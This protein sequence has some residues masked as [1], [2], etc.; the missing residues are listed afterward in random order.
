VA[1][2]GGVKSKSKYFYNGGIKAIRK[3]TTRCGYQLGGTLNHRIRVLSPDDSIQWRYLTEIQPGDVA[4]LHRGTDLW[5]SEET[6]IP[7]TNVIRSMKNVPQDIL[8]SSRLTVC[9]FIRACFGGR[10]FETKHQRMAQ[11]IQ[12]L[13]L[14]LGIISKTYLYSGKWTVEIIGRKSG[15]RFA[16]LIDPDFKAPISW[17]NDGPDP[18]YFCDDI[19]RIEDSEAPVYDLNVPE[20][21]SFVASGFVNHNTFLAAA[22]A[23]YE[24]YK[25]ILKGC[26]QDYYGL[27]PTNTIQIISVAT[28]KDQAGLLYQEV[29]GHYKSCGFFLPYTANN[30]QSF[31][32]FQTP[33]DI[34]KFGRYVDD[35]GGAKATL[36]VTFRSCIAKG[37]RGAGNIVVILDE[38]A[39]FTDNGQS[40]A[41]EVYKAVTPS[42]STF[43]AKDPITKMPLPGPNGE[44][45]V[46]ESRVISISSPL[47]KSGQF[48]KLFQLAMK[49]GK[50]A[51]NMLA[52]QAPTWEVNP[53]IPISELESEYYKDSASFLVEF[54]GQFSSRTRG[55][56]EREVDLQACVEPGLR[57]VLS[58]PARRPH[59][60]GIDVGLV[61]DWTAIA[62]GHHDVRDGERVVLLDYI[63]RIHAGEGRYRDK[64]R[65]DFDDVANWIY[66]LSRRFY[67]QE[68]IFDQWGSIP[69]ED[70]LAKRGLRQLRGHKFSRPELSD[71]FQNFKS[72]MWD[73]RIVLYDYPIPDDRAHCDYIMELLDLEADAHSKY[74]IDVHKPNL[75]DKSDDMSDALVRM[76]WLASQGMS[77]TKT[78]SGTYRGG[79]SEFAVAKARQAESMQRKAMVRAR[80][81]GSDPARMPARY[82]RGGHFTAGRF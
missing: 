59:F 60:I 27:I 70:A 79:P 22:I 6:D 8:K 32:R 24:T 56:L 71:I 82:H 73:R 4:I 76:V 25:L 36:K 62:I 64:E 48:Y 61:N 52:I 28:D 7:G 26:P 55:W 75:E 5:G 68:G 49:G 17:K 19:V 57:P 43:S 35:P 81:P 45:G 44:D 12:V 16:E 67:I 1:Q 78:V 39:H 30:T 10:L 21:E 69:L 18:C 38:M 54:G 9:R 58:A 66:D 50:A 42:K 31:A 33:H 65:L 23:A 37:L 41:E 40:S 77:K 20:G 13:L 11:E 46:V 3:I 80:R 2:E 53:T 72:L 14:N 51:K 74:L 34:E 15:A 29:S 47:G 63:D